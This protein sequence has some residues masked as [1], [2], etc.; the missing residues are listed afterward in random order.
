MVVRYIGSSRRCKTYVR[1]NLELVDVVG[2]VSSSALGCPV[3]E[4]P[5]F[6]QFQRIPMI[7][8]ASMVSEVG[9]KEMSVT[10][11]VD[12]AKTRMQVTPNNGGFFAVLRRAVKTEGV[13][14]VIYLYED[15]RNMLAGG[16]DKG[17]SAPLWAKAVAGASAGGI[18]Q[19]LASPADL[20]KVRL[21]TGGSKY[22]GFVDCLRQVYKAEG[23][24]GFYRGWQPNVTRA[25]IVN[26]GEL[27]TYDEAKRAIKTAT[28]WEE[29]VV[30]HTSSAL[31]SGF[32]AALLSTPA[33]VCK[34]RVM[35]GMY[36]TMVSC[37]VG[38]VKNEGVAALWKGFGP[39]WLRLG[40]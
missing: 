39:N 32:V 26:I 2:V 36:P 38:T 37:L 3:P 28:E 34:S 30:L 9:A 22:N 27:A 21:Q 40:P 11:P 10:F 7:Q 5:L 15:F 23:A 33:D 20:V 4:N 6:Q 29:G 8:A 14:S 13:G 25:A 19:L 1:V 31:C 18:G 24:K 17:R 12:F 35:S 16:D